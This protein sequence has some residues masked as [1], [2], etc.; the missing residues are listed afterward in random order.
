VEVLP[1]S[2]ADKK[3][4]GNGR[5]SPNQYPF[6]DEPKD[7]FQWSWNPFV[8][9][10]RLCGRSFRY[11]LAIGL[12]IGVIIFLFYNFFHSFGGA[13]TANTVDTVFNKAV[14]N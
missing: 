12:I 7:R 5:E 13:A 11:K 6:L 9:M 1:K 2:I 10:A 4:S 3:P 14:V 8:L